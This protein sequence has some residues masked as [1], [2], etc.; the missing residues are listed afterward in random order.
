M[1]D[2]KRFGERDSMNVDPMNDEGFGDLERGRLRERDLERFG[3]IWRVF[4]RLVYLNAR[5]SVHLPSLSIYQTGLSE[6]ITINI[7]SKQK[8]IKKSS[9]RMN[10]R[11]NDFAPILSTVN[12]ILNDVMISTEHVQIN[13]LITYVCGFDERWRIWRGRYYA[14]GSYER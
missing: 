1:K 10:Y 7:I 9:W 5:Y 8:I 11:K 4:T 2:L 13:D 14:C 3:E 12:S 6:G